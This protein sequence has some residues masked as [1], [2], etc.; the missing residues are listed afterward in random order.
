MLVKALLLF[1]IVPLIEVWFLVRLG[2][3]IGAFPTIFLVAVTGFIG[4]FLAK[5]QGFIV[6]HR[7]QRKLASGAFPTDELYNGACILIGG[8]LLLTPG[9]FTDLFGLS[10]LIPF[11]RVFWKMVFS[12]IIKKLIKDGKVTVHTN[13][14]EFWGNTGSEKSDYIDTD[15]EVN[16]DED[17]DEDYH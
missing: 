8:T 7:L 15:F 1:T 12:R 4:V 10:L 16:Y 13:N 11:T 2:Q 3:N 9:L 14:Q 6:I 5:S 17:K